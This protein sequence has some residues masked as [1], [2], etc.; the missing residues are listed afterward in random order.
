MQYICYANRKKLL[1]LD[2]RETFFFKPVSTVHYHYMCKNLLSRIESKPEEI[3][4][5][6][7][8]NCKGSIDKTT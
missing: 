7:N 6:A 1:S 2:C 4:C 5:L 3:V 8:V